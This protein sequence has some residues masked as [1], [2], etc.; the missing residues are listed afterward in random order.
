L[1]RSFRCPCGYYGDT[2]RE[3][4]CTPAIIQRYLGK[5]SG[6]LLDRIDI[7]IEVPAVPFRELRAGEVAESSEDMR[8]R[9]AGAGGA[10]ARDSARARIQQRAHADE[11]DPQTVRARRNW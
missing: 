9:A 10:G 7:Q 2:T 3:R 4:R 6:P 11:D 8:G 1:G 5:I